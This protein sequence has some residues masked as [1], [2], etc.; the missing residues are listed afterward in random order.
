MMSDLMA[1]DRRINATGPDTKSLDSKSSGSGEEEQKCRR[2][3]LGLVESEQMGMRAQFGR[4][5]T[6][7]RPSHD[8]Q[9]AEHG[10]YSPCS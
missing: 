9:H 1:S 10:R 7:A 8:S 3:Q 2:T 6:W 5:V 4:L